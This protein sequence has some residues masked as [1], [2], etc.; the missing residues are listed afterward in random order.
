MVARVRIGAPRLPG[1]GVLNPVL[2]IQQ[3]IC[4]AVAVKAAALEQVDHP[5]GRLRTVQLPHLLCRRGTSPIPLPRPPPRLAARAAAPR[6]ECGKMLYPE[7]RCPANRPSPKSTS[8]PGFA[9]SPRSSST[10]TSRAALSP[11]PWSRSR[12][13]TTPHR[14]PSPTPAPSH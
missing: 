3:R 8:P 2:E 10:S 14:S 5:L 12:S 1:E 7:E 9:I 4:V 11:K 6:H 13:A